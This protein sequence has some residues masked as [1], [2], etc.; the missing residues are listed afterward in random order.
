MWAKISGTWRVTH[1]CYLVART[2]SASAEP[3]CNFG[4][5]GGDSS[6]RYGSVPPLAPASPPEVLLQSLASRLSS[7]TG[8]A[9]RCSLQELTPV[10]QPLTS[11]GWKQVG[12]RC[13]GFPED[14]SPGWPTMGNRLSNAPVKALS[15]SSHTPLPPSFLLPGITTPPPPQ[16]NFLHANPRFRLCFC[17]NQN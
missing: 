10:G 1:T 3:T 7:R 14:L 8:A 2:T 5:C 4:R 13:S 16:I 17:R 11:G 9:C 12:K 15:S 6:A